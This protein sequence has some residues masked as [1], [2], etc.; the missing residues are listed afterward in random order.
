MQSRI[1]CNGLYECY[2]ILFEA[3]ISCLEG[4]N[5]LPNKRTLVTDAAKHLNIMKAR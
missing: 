5:A 4:V 1:Y 2:Q 3:L